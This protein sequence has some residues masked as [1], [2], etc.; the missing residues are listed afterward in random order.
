MGYKRRNVP[1]L[2]VVIAS[3]HS[4]TTIQGCLVSLQEQTCQPDEVIL[5]DSGCDGTAELVGREFPHVRLFAF[6]ERKYPGDARNIGLQ[7]ASGDVVAFLDSDCIVPADWAEQIL[8]A[9]QGPDPLIGGAFENANPTSQIGWAA[10]FCELSQW[11]PGGR[12][13]R[14]HEVPTGSLSI[15]RW[16]FEKYGPFLERTYCSDTAFNW[17]ARADGQLPVF[18]PAIRVRHFNFTRLRRFLPKQVMHGRAF[19]TVRIQE[20]KMRAQS[21][22]VYALGS[23]LLPLLLLSRI[24]VRVLRNRIYIGQFVQASPIV[25]LGLAAWS[26]GEF[27]GYW[28]GLL[29]FLGVAGAPRSL[30]GSA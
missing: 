5:V 2:S 17:R 22:A 25:L 3:Y 12:A 8:L 23:P 26:C 21:T 13:R 14:V 19:A 9:H 11:M 16:A 30:K 29:D 20:Q 27:L 28:N 18:Q 4:F 1:G 10:Y 15:K 6:S 7:H 24:L